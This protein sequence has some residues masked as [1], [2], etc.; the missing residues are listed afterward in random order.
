[1]PV[2]VIRAG[3]PAALSAQAA[4]RYVYIGRPS[5]WG[6]PW[7]VGVRYPHKA[8]D[9]ATRAQVIDW[10]R[11]YWYSDLMAPMRQHALDTIPVDACLGCYC[12][13]KPCHG[14]VIAEFLNRMRTPSADAR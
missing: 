10:Y 2:T 9:H 1:M 6:N 3:T 7:H 5:P 8:P 4:G 12:F 14:D 13:P 11:T